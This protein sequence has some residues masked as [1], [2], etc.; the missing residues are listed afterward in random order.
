VFRKQRGG[1]VPVE[2]QPGIS[3]DEF[4]ETISGLSE[5]DQILL[6]VSDDLRR[7]LPE[8]E[9]TAKGPHGRRSPQ[10]KRGG[11]G[12]SAQRSSASAKRSTGGKPGATGGHRKGGTP[13]GGKKAHVPA[14]SEGDATAEPQGKAGDTAEAPAAS[15]S[16]SDDEAKKPAESKEEGK[17]TN[18]ATQAKAGEGSTP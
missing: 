18:D 5:G 8:V 3:N 12:R 4:V 7:L 16:E 2:I 15:P 6:A 17:S 13:D 10:A 14:K 11:G 1:A 9:P